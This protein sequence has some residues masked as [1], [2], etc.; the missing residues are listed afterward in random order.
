ML[1]IVQ[2]VCMILCTDDG[3]GRPMDSLS[4]SQLNSALKVFGVS[5]IST[6]TSNCVQAQLA[7]E[8]F[9]LLS[10]WASKIS[11]L[12]FLHALTPLKR[13]RRILRIAC[14]IL[15]LW[16]LTGTFSTIFQCAVPR[17][18]DYLSGKCFNRVRLSPQFLLRITDTPRWHLVYPW[19][20]SIFC[21]KSHLSSFQSSSSCH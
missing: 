14:I 3:L 12:L 7:S 19:A 1:A 16:V 4:A 6:L 10:L 20:S 15:T 11:V 9:F 2:S 8:V 13:H 17:T 21:R 5:Y 18:W